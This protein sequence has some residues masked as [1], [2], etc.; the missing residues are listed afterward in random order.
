MD[1]KTAQAKPEFLAFYG[2]QLHAYAFALENP[3][4]RTIGLAP[5]SKLGLL[6]VEPADMDQTA[7]GRIAYLGKVTWQE[8]PLNL[9]GFQAFLGEVLGVLELPAPPPAHEKCSFCQYRELARQSGL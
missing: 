5:I 7:D 3:A 8:I 1:F 6:V 2:R 4:P 9:T